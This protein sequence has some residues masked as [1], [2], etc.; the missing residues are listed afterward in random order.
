MDPVVPG[1]QALLADAA[2]LGGVLHG[3]QCLATGDDWVHLRFCATCG[4]VGCCDDSTNRHASRHAAEAGHPVM[5]SKEPG[6]NWAWCVDH[7]MG[8]Q[9]PPP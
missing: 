6:E 8:T 5:R 1:G 3:E 2:R 7:R 9:L 4:Q